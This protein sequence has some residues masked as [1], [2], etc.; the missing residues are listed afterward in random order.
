MTKGEYISF[1]QNNL[2]QLDQTARYHSKQVEYAIE[3]VFNQ[4]Y[5]DMAKKSPNS[6]ERYSV[7]RL[8]VSSSLDV[9]TQRYVAPTEANTWF[10]PSIDELSAMHDNLHS[11]GVGGFASAYYWSSGEDDNTNAWGKDF[12]S[13]YQYVDSKASTNYVRAVRTFTPLA[14]AYSLRD[15][16]PAGGLIFYIDGTTY[17]EAAPSDQ[18]ASQVWSNIINVAIG[19]TG[20]AIGTGLANTAAII[21][22]AGHT[23]S[24]AKVCDDYENNTATLD[25]KYVDLPLKASGVLGVRLSTSTTLAFVPMTT[26]EMDLAYG[27]DLTLGSSLIGYS[28]QNGQLEFFG[29]SADATTLTV[30]IVQQF[31][32]YA[33]TDEVYPPYG[34]DFNITGQVLQILSQIPPKDLVNDNSDIKNG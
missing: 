27:A 18:S 15:V 3:K 31:S 4:V 20:T 7:L 33:S 6:L 32:E 2:T 21:A 29:M 9:N 13:G 30:R 16:G 5:Y 12:D 14:G 8:G 28:A 25:L 24:A 34:K 10:L 11:E 17:Y 1:I 22:Q 19:T 23:D 26:M